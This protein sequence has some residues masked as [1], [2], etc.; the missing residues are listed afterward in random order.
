MSWMAIRAFSA[1]I[2]PQRMTADA[3][4][5]SAD[6][7]YAEYAPHSVFSRMKG[8]PARGMQCRASKYGN[9]GLHTK[10]GRLSFKSVINACGSM[11]PEC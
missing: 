11:Q 3:V 1:I 9:Y 4:Y 2:T 8:K 5:R 10:N 6:S 7:P